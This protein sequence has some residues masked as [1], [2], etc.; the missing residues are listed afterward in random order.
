MLYDKYTTKN[1]VEMMDHIFLQMQHQLV[2]YRI[3]KCHCDLNQSPSS[4]NNVLVKINA[5]RKGMKAWE[6]LWTLAT[7]MSWNIWRK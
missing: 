6:R 7:T 2:D 1:R 5:L 4:F 3:H